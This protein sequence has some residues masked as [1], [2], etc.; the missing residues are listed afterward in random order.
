MSK[1]VLKIELFA[2]NL[3]KFE[4]ILAACGR[5]FFVLH[6]VTGGCPTNDAFVLFYNKALSCLDSAIR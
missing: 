5:N 6:F 3:R 4:E 2:K 1:K